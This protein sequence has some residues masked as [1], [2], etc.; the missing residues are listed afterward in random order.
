MIL[1]GLL[2]V[3]SIC[4]ASQDRLCLPARGMCLCVKR[5]PLGVGSAHPR[6][7]KEVITAAGRV[8]GVSGTPVCGLIQ[9]SAFQN[10]MSR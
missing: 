1:D 6:A 10:L 4:T 7:L 2:N 5:W 8:P 3:L 9:L